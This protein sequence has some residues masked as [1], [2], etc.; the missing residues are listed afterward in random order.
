M[1]KIIIPR[2]LCDQNYEVLYVTETPLLTW[3]VELWRMQRVSSVQE[4]VSCVR[5]VVSQRSCEGSRECGLVVISS[6]RLY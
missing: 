1:I 3:E 5:W 6:G 2:S 4:P